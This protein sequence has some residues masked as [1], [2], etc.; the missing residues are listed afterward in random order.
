MVC[1]LLKSGALACVSVFWKGKGM[2]PGVDGASGEKDDA[3]KRQEGGGIQQQDYFDLNT[4]RGCRQPWFSHREARLATSQYIMRNRIVASSEYSSSGYSRTSDG[5]P[6]Q[7]DLAAS[8]ST[9][10]DAA[11]TTFP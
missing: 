2:K 4:F 9:A 6:G 5:K 7:S 3:W 11:L 1:K 8:P 10:G